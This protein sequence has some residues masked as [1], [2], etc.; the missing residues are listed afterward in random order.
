[1]TGEIS[2]KSTPDRAAVK[3]THPDGHQQ[4]I[5]NV[6]PVTIPALGKGTYK[7]S[8]SVDEAGQIY[9]GAKE[10]EVKDGETTTVDITILAP[11]IN[12]S[13]N[14]VCFYSV[15]MTAIF[16]A[17][18]IGTRLNIIIIPPEDLT[19]L[20]IYLSCS[21]ALG[22]LAFSLYVLV[23]HVGNLEDYKPIYSKSYYLRPFIGILYGLF[24]VFFVLG[25][26]MT[27]SGVNTPQNLYTT[28][29][30]M[31]YLGLAFLV[32]YAEEPFSIQLKDLAEALF[33]EPPSSDTKK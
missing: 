29:A 7:V 20:I 23:W 28:N 17:I 1:M 5:Q 11:S 32:G 18:A 27:M 16:V 2:V 21:G 31:F 30:F 25:G 3:L 33:K 4:D 26:L 6:T 13:I 24:V 19:R 10:V 12:S 14:S 9:S 15:F 22:A 8:V